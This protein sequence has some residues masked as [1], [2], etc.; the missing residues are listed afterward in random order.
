VY[1]WVLI[2]LLLQFSYAARIKDVARIDGLS[3]VQLVGYGLVVG[4]DGTGDGNRTLFTSQT[5]MNMLRNLGIEISGDN[6]RLRNVAAVMVTSNMRPFLKKG[7]RVD[8][9]LSSLGDARSLAGG[10]LLMTPLIGPDQEVYALAQGPVSVGGMNTSAVASRASVS[11]NHVLTATIPGGGIIQQEKIVGNISSNE[12]R[13]SL[14][15]PDF[16]SAVAMAEVLNLV[17]PGTAQ[18]MD[19]ATVSV[20]VPEA[21]QNNL[22]VFIAESE[23]LTFA[24]STHAKVILNEKSGTIVAGADVR[25]SEVAVSHGNITIRV[26]QRERTSQPN[27]YTQGVTRQD[28][29]ESVEVEEGTADVRVMPAVTNVGELAQALNSLGVKPR[30][31]VTIFQAIKRAGALHAELV[32]M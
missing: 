23:N 24:I 4:L 28:R 6:I 27:P 8:V 20:R 25:I 30:D 5:V 15:E 7:S 12:L 19:A 32:V 14:N 10:T 2:L 13:W 31:I 16:S 21:F 17:Y 3:D 29:E 9:T 22:M 11:R 1:K 26:N 18:A